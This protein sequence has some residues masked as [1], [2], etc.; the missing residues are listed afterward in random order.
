MRT[1]QERAP[2]SEPIC[3]DARKAWW[4]PSVDSLR[5]GAFWTLAKLEFVTQRMEADLI[6][7]GAQIVTIA[8]S[9]SKLIQGRVGAIQKFAA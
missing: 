8:D 6:A 9:L 3:R 5:G 2:A 7:M 4:G 1:L